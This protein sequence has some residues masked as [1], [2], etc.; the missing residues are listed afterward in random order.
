MISLTEKLCELKSPA[1]A[2]GAALKAQASP[3]GGRSKQ[4]LT[5]AERGTMPLADRHFPKCRK[6][7]TG[8][9]LFACRTQ[10]ARTPHYEPCIPLLSRPGR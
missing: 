4:G 6:V 5:Q 9:S 3:R 7:E 10:T 2:N 8:L 1:D